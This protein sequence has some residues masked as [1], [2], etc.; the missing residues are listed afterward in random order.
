MLSDQFLINIS[1]SLQVPDDPHHPVDLY[2]SKLRDIVDEHAPSRTKEGLQRQMLPWCNKNIQ[3]A[4]RHIWYYEWLWIRTSL[5][6]H[7]K[8]FKVSKILGKNT[9]ASAKSEYYNKRLKHL[10]Q[11]KG[12]FLV[13]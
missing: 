5:C 12:L 8:M 7:Y 3:A 6:V 11:T 9:L 2:V 10:R 4:K 1:L 13:L